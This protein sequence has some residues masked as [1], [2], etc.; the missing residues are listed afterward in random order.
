MNHNLIQVCSDIH[1][2]RND[3]DDISKIIIPSAEI[4][5]LAGDIGNPMSEIYTHF[6]DYY[7]KLFKIILLITGNHEYYGNSISET[8]EKIEDICSLYKN[9]HFLNNKIFKYEDI[10]FIGTTLWSLIPD[11]YVIN[12]ELSD[13]KD[14]KLI[15]DF[16]LDRHRRL[17]KENLEFIEN[18]LGKKSIIITHHAPSMKCIADEYKNDV[19]NCCFASNLDNLFMNNKVLGWIYGHTHNNYFSINNN[20]FMYSNCYRTNN[21]NPSF[22]I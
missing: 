3:I 10:V 11:H 20:K 8:E 6:L 22:V 18:N 4:L 9:I 1:L 19:V 13:M 21:Y 17:F 16:T 5:V 15:K 2:E 12:N 7:S 14:F